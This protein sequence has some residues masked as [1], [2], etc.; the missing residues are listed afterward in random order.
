MM[1]QDL[2][3][4]LMAFR[5]SELPA[6]RCER[7]LARLRLDEPF[8]RSFVD[9]LKMLG[10]LKAVQSSEP[11][12]IALQEELGWGGGESEGLEAFVE[13]TMREFTE[14]PPPSGSDRRPGAR[15]LVA[16]AALLVV[17]AVATGLALW[18][19]AAPSPADR[20]PP[21]AMGT[22]LALVAKL[23]GVRWEAAP[24]PSPIEG[25][26][27]AGG[28][29]S[30][31][32]GKAVLSFLSGVTL[33]LEGPSDVDLLT[34]SRVYCRRGKLRVRVPRGAEGFV[35]TS[36]GSAVVDLG[37]E[38]AM[39]VESDGRSRVMVFEGAAD[40][41]LLDARGF[42]RRTLRF[43]HGKEYELDPNRDRMVETVPRPEA[44]VAT[45]DMGAP[46]LDLDPEYPSEVMALRP[47]G[48]WRFESMD[49]SS[50]PNEVAGG[51]PLRARGPI[52]LFR[53]AGGNRCAVFPPGS[54]GQFLTTD[55]LWEITAGPSHAVEL[56]A[57]TESVGQAVVLVGLYAPTELL[58]PEFKYMHTELIGMTSYEPHHV[59]KP[60]SVRFLCRRLIGGRVDY[61]LYSA[62][63]YSPGVWHHIVAQRDGEDLELYFDGM[64]E[65]SRMLEPLVKPPPCCL[66]VGRRTVDPLDT[67]K[68]SR[69]FVG[70]I[71]ELAVYDHALP[72]EEIRRHF[73]MG[74][75]SGGRP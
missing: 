57:M 67:V 23:D 28:R 38:F 5:G 30:L 55:D 11:R 58:P 75:P 15:R 72:E 17:G 54:P 12:W 74:R 36:P 52:R 19:P 49:D 13:A 60:G 71:D 18:H 56:W 26:M 21:V 42:A 69:S 50:V 61:N 29:L 45:P 64:R 25:S 31:S 63:V 8:R 3:D 48:Y 9:E 70:R 24:S 62:K 73:E 68:D 32:S 20:P 37:T 6:D 43:E 44:F 65:S 16:V 35:V 4:L 14:S 59:D 10:M 41:S 47:Q 53:N 39:N 1:D 27:L 7:L 40:A 2:V 51:R 66:V 34:N 22:L 46:P 33:T